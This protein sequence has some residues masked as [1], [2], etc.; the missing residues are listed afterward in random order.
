LVAAITVAPIAVLLKGLTV[1]VKD[2]QIEQSQRTRC[3]I[4]KYD[5]CT[6]IDA[7]IAR[8]RDLAT[9]VQ[10]QKITDGIAKF[11]LELLEQKAKLRS[12][13]EKAASG[14]RPLR[15]FPVRDFYYLNR[16]VAPS[17]RPCPSERAS[18]RSAIVA[19]L[20]WSAWANCQRC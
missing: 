5:E 16:L 8:L 11:I 4:A 19:T 10:N 7:K 12:E 14:W 2:I 6:E 17:S 3:P 13:R 15:I 1:A 20:R 9:R 18:R